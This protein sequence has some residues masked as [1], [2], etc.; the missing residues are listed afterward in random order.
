MPINIGI[1][2]FIGLLIPLFLIKK[3]Y[4]KNKNQTL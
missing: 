1:L 4:N 2:I 3:L